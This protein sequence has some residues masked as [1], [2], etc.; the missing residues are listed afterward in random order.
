[1]L[2]MGLSTSMALSERMKRSIAFEQ[3][4]GSRK[5]TI[6]YSSVKAVARASVQSF[7]LG[8]QASCLHK[9]EESVK[10]GG[11]DARAPKPQ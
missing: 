2:A 1:M 4:A 9:S 6:S 8:A 5:P 11:R 3:L 10:Y 7:F